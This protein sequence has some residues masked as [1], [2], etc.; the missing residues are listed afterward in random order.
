MVLVAETLGHCIMTE[1]SLLILS[2]NDEYV[3]IVFKYMCNIYLRYNNNIGTN[4]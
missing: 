3:S 2:S 1:H 4:M